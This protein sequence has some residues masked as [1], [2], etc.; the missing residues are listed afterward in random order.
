M[1]PITI[2]LAGPL[3][4]VAERT[5][6]LRLA[7][8]LRAL[9]Y[10]IILPQQRATDFITSDG[11]DLKEMAADCAVQAS[12][13]NNILVANLDGPEA[14]SGTAVEYGLAI[15]AVGR[16]ITYRTDIRTAREKEVGINAMFGL[17]GTTH[18]HMSCLVN[19][20]EDVQAFYTELARA[21]HWAIVTE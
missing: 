2:Y 15:C 21:I 3:F 1:K 8:E 12:N 6:N 11:L 7:R 9:G 18:I 13:P 14:D 16:A 20:D 19:S 10:E 4:T 5:H 17:R